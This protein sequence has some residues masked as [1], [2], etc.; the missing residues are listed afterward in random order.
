MLRARH[1]LSTTGATV[2]S[3]GLALG[4]TVLVARL[5]TPEQNGHYAQFV[6]VF[7]LAFIA[8]NFGLGP[9]STFFVASGRA[10]V[11]SVSLV[12]LVVLVALAAVMS[13]VAWLFH[14]LTLDREI[15]RLLKIPPEMLHIGLFAGILLLAFNQVVAILMGGHRY[16]LVNVLSVLKAGLSL[17]LVGFV[18]FAWMRS[19]ASVAI[20]QATAIAITVVLSV[21]LGHRSFARTDG[22]SLAVDGS[23]PG[24]RQMV[25]YGSLVYL[26]NLLHYLA[27]RGLLLLLSYF[28]APEYVGFLSL[29]LLLL[30]VTLL[31]PSAIGQLVFPQSSTSG[32][33][34]AALETVVRVNVYISL[35]LV[36]LIALTARAFVTTLVGPAYE[37]V[38]LV[39]IHLTPSVVLLAVPRILSQLLSGQGHPGYPLTAA[40]LS[41]A[42]GAAVAAWAVPRFGYLGAAWVTNMV[43]LITAVVTMFG[44]CRVHR[45]GVLQVLL[46]RQQDWLSLRRLATRLAG[47]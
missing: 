19:V 25:S 39:L 43:A 15:E 40:A 5:L 38:A 32:F 20:A 44:Y 36:A 2:A 33:D 42:F 45:V 9:A 12:N 41:L 10:S 27:M 8:L 24:L 35:V 23:S 31:L 14:Q 6:V 26:S 28:S 13:I 34:S 47:R 1:I 16:D 17:V 18:G 7:N 21:W 37:P 22:P 4:L 30:E 3:G 11:R 29:A 46:P